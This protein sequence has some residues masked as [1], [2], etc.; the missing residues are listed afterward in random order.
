MEC[1]PLLFL[2]R[3]GLARP[4]SKFRALYFQVVAKNGSWAEGPEKLCF[5]ESQLFLC[6]NPFSSTL[7]DS[8]ESFL[9]VLAQGPSAFIPGLCQPMVCL[10][11]P[12]TL[13]SLSLD[14]EVVSVSAPAVLSLKVSWSG[15][16]GS[17]V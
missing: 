17:Q 6:P 14:Q 2:N 9:V 10:Q 13:S 5:S 8:G 15:L 4:G 16:F 11:S 12:A 1:V 7:K 3:A